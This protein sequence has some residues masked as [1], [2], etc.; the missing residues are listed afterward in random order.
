MD[1][2]ETGCE[3]GHWFQLPKN[4]FQRWTLGKTALNV[5]EFRDWDSGTMR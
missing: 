4:K 5:V 1:H 3:N 2:N